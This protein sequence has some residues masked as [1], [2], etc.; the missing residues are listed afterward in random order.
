MDSLFKTIDK[1][2]GNTI[3]TILSPF[4]IF[5]KRKIAKPN[6]ILIVRLW[7]LGESLLTFPMISKIKKEFPQAK[8]AVLCRNANKEPFQL[9]KEVDEII[10][11]E[12]SDLFSLFKKFK[13]Y[14]FT[15]DTEPW[16]KVSALLSFWLGKRRIGFSHGLRKLMYTD[17]V[18]F[19]DQQYEADTFLD[20]L[21]PLGVKAK[22]ESYKRLEVPVKDKKAVDDLLKANGIKKTDKLI[23]IC[24]GAEDALYRMWMPGGFAAVSDY[25][26]KKYHAKIIVLGVKKEWDLC[27]SV[28][29]MSRHGHEMINLAGKT[30]KTQ[31]FYLIDQL[32][33]VIT[34]DT[35]TMHAAAVQDVK[36][37]SLF[38]PNL[39]VR[40]A[41]RTKG[42]IS[43]YHGNK[44]N[45][46]INVHK[47]EIPSGDDRRFYEPIEKITIDEV[48][49]ACDK[50]L[51]KK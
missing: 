30:S 21:H 11:F 48:K 51:R 10:F 44:K 14:D 43:I 7:T 18:H 16:F 13:K 35:G 49:K 42:S 32:D 24:P 17:K 40:F 20:L 22:F 34:N 12:P 6:K 50:A 36:T 3:I 47:G 23:A 46:F 28:R 39:P 5:P 33:L 27:E 37:I 1:Y 45:P 15:I 41:P 9:N 31:L 2:V 26:H 38:G 19:N 8:I 25:L 29:G 4:S